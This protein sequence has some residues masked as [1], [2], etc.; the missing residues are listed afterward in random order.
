[1]HFSF[2][3]YGKRSEVELLLRDM[4]AQKHYL[5]LDNGKKVPIQGQV[6]VLPFGIIEYVCPKED[7]YL[8]LNTLQSV[9]NPYNL[10]RIIISTIRKILGLKFKKK[11]FDI[12]NAQKYLWIK[13][14]VS[15]IFLGIREDGEIF[16]SLLNTNHEAI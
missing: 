10:P 7:Q 1:M 8:V 5:K 13:D 6:R 12:D 15:I 2:I 3:P 4:E 9:E 16:D 14:N 11:V